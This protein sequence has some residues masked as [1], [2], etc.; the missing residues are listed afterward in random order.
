MTGDKDPALSNRESL[1]LLIAGGAAIGGGGLIT[2]AAHLGYLAT[3]RPTHGLPINPFALL[4]ATADGRVMWPITATVVLA[5][6]VV[7]LTVITVAMWRWWKIRHPARPWIDATAALLAHGTELAPL[8]ESAVRDK[9]AM[10]GVVM[11]EATVP[12]LSLGIAVADR[13]ALWADYEMLHIDIWGPRQG[14]STSRAVPAICE[15]PG[16]VIV[17]SNKRDLVDDTRGIREKHGRCWIFDPQAVTADA[18]PTWWWNPLAAVRTEVDAAQLASHFADGD[19]GQAVRKDAFFD[20]EGE[21]LLAALFLAAAVAVE[22]ITRVYEWISDPDDLQP[23]RVLET[24]WPLIATG[25]R[26]QYELDRRT[27]SGVFAT[28]RKMAASLRL[29]SIRRWVTS[30]GPGD[31]RPQ[32]DPAALA[33]SRDTLYMLSLEG[34]GSCGPLVNA[35]TASVLEAATG[36]GSQ[37][38]MGRLATPLVCVLDEAANVVRWRDLP[39]RYSHFGSRGILVLTILQS[40]SQGVRCW[41]TEGMNALWSAAGV[42]IVGSGVDDN[43]FLRRRSDSIGDREQLRGTLTRHHGSVSR[44]YQLTDKRTLTLA[45][46]TA[47]PRG[48]AL[49]WAA[50]MRPVLIETVPWMRRPYATAV[51]ASRE[52]YG[53]T[54]TTTPSPDS[55]Q[56]GTAQDLVPR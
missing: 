43:E 8:T 9:A 56:A 31:E 27:R 46:L 51:A 16:P 52:R 12:G 15:A 39:K 30:D 41:G 32:L 40:W 45:D 19:D 4:V 28:G 38:P 34:A 37:Q 26:A 55:G 14:K 20:P 23:V 48:R 35:L 42:R 21:S 2:S 29:A 24:R 33:T 3:G 25:L 10:L 7:T 50:G 53:P 36:I 49:I 17:T 1:A 6:E 47:I 44:S 13:I 5:V 54:G 18:E 11:P 22:P